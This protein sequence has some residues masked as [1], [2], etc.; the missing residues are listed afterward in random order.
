MKTKEKQTT[1]IRKSVAGILFMLVCIFAF[2]WV[3]SA[4]MQYRDEISREHN[5]R[6]N[7]D[8]IDDRLCIRGAIDEYGNPDCYLKD[9]FST[10]DFVYGYYTLHFKSLSHFDS[11]EELI[12]EIFDADN[13]G[14][15]LLWCYEGKV[16][17]TIT[18]NIGNNEG[19][20]FYIRIQGPRNFQY[21]FYF[22]FHKARNWEDEHNETLENANRI[23]FNYKMHA[24]TGCFEYNHTYDYDYYEVEIPSTGIMTFE[25][26][27]TPKKNHTVMI[28]DEKRKALWQTK[29]TSGSHVSKKLKVKPGKIYIKIFGTNNERYD[30]IVKHKQ[31]T[32]EPGRTKITGRWGLNNAIKFTWKNPGGIF[33]GYQIQYSKDKKFNSGVSSKWIGG[34][35]TTKIVIGNLE[36]K[37]DYYVRIRT[38]NK[39]NNKTY[40][41][42]WCDV[43]CIHSY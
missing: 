4:E 19:E 15:Y 26:D 11:D 2:S 8:R 42:A 33:S 1:K 25:M 28:F 16:Q 24:N 10:N 5:D 32:N 14:S 35:K 21:Q 31:T 34:K 23:K 6:L 39:V 41:S 17:K 13:Y 27:R 43:K 9:S 38:F 20:G 29:I 22:D 7:P 40:Y 3:V 37:T 36:K 18:A 12:I 30:F